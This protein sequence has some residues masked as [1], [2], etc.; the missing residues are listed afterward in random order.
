MAR[1]LPVL[2]MT[3]PKAASE[4]FAAELRA[5]G[6]RFRT[7]IS[8]LFSIEV[9]EVLP[10]V[11]GIRGLIFTSANGV[12]S[13][14]ALGGPTD[15]PVYAVGSATAQAA[16]AAGMQAHSAEGD[17]DT[18]CRW[19]I[20]HEPPTPLLHVHGRHVRGDLAAQLSQGGLPCSDAV[21]YDQPSV[22]LSAEA[23]AALAGDAP[24]IA[25]VFSPRTGFLLLE[26]GAKAPLLVAAM[27]EAVAKALA[28][29]HKRKMKVARRP[30]SDAMREV[31]SDLLSRAL[32]GEF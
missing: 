5:E 22:P 20:A 17:V 29:L 10:Q 19:L 12:R 2:L 1:P 14:Q 15:L 32:A 27:S 3:R 18:L 7:V 24:V 13:W 8:P 9:A 16:G 30:E 28:P 11:A 25:P 4:R 26:E 23:R 6:L 21:V 31:V